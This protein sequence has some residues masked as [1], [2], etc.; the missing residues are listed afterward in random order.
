MQNRSSRVDEE[1]TSD[2]DLMILIFTNLNER[3][4]IVQETQVRRFVLAG[5]EEREPSTGIS[6]RQFQTPPKKKLVYTV[7]DYRNLAGIFQCLCFGIAGSLGLRLVSIGLALGPS[8]QEI[9]STI[10]GALAFPGNIA[11]HCRASF[12]YLT[13]PV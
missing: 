2:T 4:G 5:R 10:Q 7:L 3:G 13:M 6:S 12:P 8:I 11:H 1:I 9:D